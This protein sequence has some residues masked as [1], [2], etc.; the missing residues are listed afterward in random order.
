LDYGLHLAVMFSIFI[1]VGTSAHLIVG[2]LGR[3]TFSHVACMALGG[4]TAAIVERSV[5]PGTALLCAA[6]FGSVFYCIQVRLLLGV[7]N[8]SFALATL[9]AHF[10]IIGWI[11]NARSLTGGFH[12]IRHIPPL[13]IPRPWDAMA[14]AVC[15]VTFLASYVYTFNRPLGV[16]LRAVGDDLLWAKSLG[17]PAE[18]LT[19]ATVSVAGAACG[20][21]G[22]FYAMHVRYISPD[23]FVAIEAITL[24]A[25]V[26]LYKE[27]PFVAS[28]ASAFILAIAPEA[29]RFVPWF[30]TSTAKYRRIVV[31]LILLLLSLTTTYKARREGNEIHR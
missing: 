18:A 24:A 10:C 16:K 1:L 22:A 23:R 25:A 15:A 14:V 2:T 30:G 17:L 7:D 31:A 8:D 4:Y 6:A 19:L 27:R 9:A 5:S 21:A 13:G 26:L 29:V 12:G 3:L 28:V 20:L 11:G